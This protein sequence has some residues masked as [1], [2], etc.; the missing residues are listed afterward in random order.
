MAITVTRPFFL[1]IDMTAKSL[2]GPPAAGS[3]MM[4]TFCFHSSGG[5]SMVITASMSVPR[6]HC[7]SESKAKPCG[8]GVGD[9]HNCYVKM[10]NEGGLTHI[11]NCIRSRGSSNIFSM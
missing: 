2:W 6:K 3:M 7:W 1:T 11:P 5:G 9:H 10:K 4:Y 8:V